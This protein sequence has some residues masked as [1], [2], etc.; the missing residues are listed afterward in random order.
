MSSCS[1]CC[2]ELARQRTFNRVQVSYVLQPFTQLLFK[3][4]LPT[5]I[6]NSKAHPGDR[7]CIILPNMLF[8]NSWI[9]QNNLPDII[10]LTPV[11]N[12]SSL[13]FL[14]ERKELQIHLLTEFGKNN[15]RGYILQYV[16]SHWFGPAEHFSKNWTMKTVKLF[17]C[18]KFSRVQHVS[19]E[20]QGHNTQDIAGLS[21]KRLTLNLGWKEEW[22]EYITV[23]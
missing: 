14:K 12:H 9:M 8:E 16:A 5:N 1:T 22:I 4:S 21:T 13:R 6:M 11:R 19:L 10:F 18:L 2:A 7:L 20:Q 17:T 23:S 3:A 15:F